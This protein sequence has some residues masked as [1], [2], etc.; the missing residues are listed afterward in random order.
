MRKRLRAFLIAHQF[1]ANCS[2]ANILVFRDNIGSGFGS[3]FVRSVNT[4]WKDV[5]YSFYFKELASL[6]FSLAIAHN[7]VLVFPQKDWK[8]AQHSDCAI[9]SHD[10]YFLP[11]T[12]CTVPGVDGTTEGR[13]NMMRLPQIDPLKVDPEE[14][15]MHMGSWWETKAFETLMHLGL[16]RPDEFLAVSDRWWLG[17]LKSFLLRPN[18]R[19][20]LGVAKVKREIGF[21]TP[22]ITMHVRRGGK[23]TI[24]HV[25]AIPLQRYLDSA[26][27]L[28]QVYPQLQNSSLFLS[29]ESPVCPR[30]KQT[31]SRCEPNFILGVVAR[32]INLF[33]MA[34]DLH[35]QQSIRE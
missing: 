25:P 32:G 30:R 33:R 35:D 3:Y 9:K 28:K 23:I 7:R 6:A 29:T 4:S 13:W 18:R 11:T 21:T 27:N 10:C 24:E 19:T 15:I 14:R 31:T 12:N 34:L 16:N 2:A 5:P 26:Q 17:G 1:P 20:R 8:F 22:C